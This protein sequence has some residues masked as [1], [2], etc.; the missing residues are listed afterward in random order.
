M[1]EL[2]AAEQLAGDGFSS[3]R[4]AQVAFAYSQMDRREDAERYFGMLEDRARDEPV[5]ESVWAM[6]H[7]AMTDY[8][9]AYRRLENALSNPLATDQI[10][11][12]ELKA[13]PYGDSLLDGPRWQ[14]LRDRIGALN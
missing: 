2:S 8:D 9:E 4:L 6:A 7:F 14:E 1:R 3:L 13:N 5:A 11:L 10:A 12:A